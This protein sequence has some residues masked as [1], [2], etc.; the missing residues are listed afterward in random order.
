[1]THFEANRIIAET[2]WIL[3]KSATI[4]GTGEFA[5]R[6]IPGGTRLL[7]YVGEKISKRESLRRCELNNEYIF[8]LN[9]E[10]DLDGNTTWNPVRFLNHSCA[11]NCEAVLEAGRIWAVALREIPAGE[12]ITYNYGYDPEDFREHPCRC[13]QEN[14]VGFIVAEEFFGHLRA[15][16]H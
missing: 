3:F 6:R 15:P 13:G 12:E 14:C 1:M 9:D 5:R 10:N 8:A 16:R 7:E 11:P 4:H 2:E